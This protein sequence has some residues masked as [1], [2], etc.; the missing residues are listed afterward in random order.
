MKATL[1]AVHD[2]PAKNP[3]VSMLFPYPCSGCHS[4]C[5]AL[6]RGRLHVCRLS[7]VNPSKK[8][9]LLL[10]VDTCPERRR[11][12]FP[13]VRPSTPG[14]S[15]VGR[16]AGR[17]TRGVDYLLSTR[18]SAVFDQYTKPGRSAGARPSGLNGGNKHL[19]LF[20]FQS[21]SPLPSLSKPLLPL[22]LPSVLPSPIP[23]PALATAAVSEPFA[24]TTANGPRRSRKCRNVNVKERHDCMITRPTHTS[25]SVA[26]SPVTYP[27]SKIYNG[28]HEALTAMVSAC[29]YPPLVR[30]QKNGGVKGGAGA[31][32]K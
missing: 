5:D 10:T 14:H 7:R 1:T 11:A 3:P 13:Y 17:G 4:C 23:A 32:V 30:R 18:M 20:Y 31:G 28:R 25:N 12:R 16:G 26:W 21:S 24:R 8:S 19:L 9:A 27:C 15:S 2:S 6:Y 29:G 22:P